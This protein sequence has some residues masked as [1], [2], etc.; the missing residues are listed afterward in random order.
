MTPSRIPSRGFLRRMPARR[1]RDRREAGRVLA[2]ELDSYRGKPDLL[3]LGLARGGI[4]VAWEV[5]A[6][7][8]AE[9]DV[10]VVRKLGV[11]RWPELAMGALASGGRVVMNDDV[12]SSLHI[13]EDEVRSVIESETAELRRREHAYRGDR[14]EAD[15]RGRTVVLVDDG[16]ATGASMLAAVRAVR[17]AGARSVVVA[18]PVGPRSARRQLAAEANDV[19]FATMPVDFDAV[20]QLYADFHQITDDEVRALLATPARDVPRQ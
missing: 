14:A 5:A 20:G 8:G 7:L 9:L 3:V 11:P 6:A 4:P 2:A 13:S 19:V 16:I 12:V 17:A 15:P 18:V 10:S 1:Y